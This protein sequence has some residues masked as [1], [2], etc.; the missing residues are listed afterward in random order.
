LNV[1]EYKMSNP[2]WLKQVQ[3]VPA[4]AASANG[5][6]ET[7]AALGAIADA[8]LT[9]GQ[10]RFAA[11]EVVGVIVKRGAGVK[12]VV[13]VSTGNA[14]ADV[15]RLAKMSGVDVANV[16]LMSA[17]AM[18]SEHYQGVASCAAIL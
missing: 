18:L 10:E 4:P 7:G 15:A 1:E 3:E 11:G 6:S 16:S 5:K 12:H 17:A 14:K 8:M 9:E 13:M 2:D